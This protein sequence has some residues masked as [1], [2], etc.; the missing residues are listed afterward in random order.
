MND[1]PHEDH[2]FDFL[3]D[4]D[5]QGRP[6]GAVP[7]APPL[8]PRAD[9]GVDLDSD[10]EAFDPPEDMQA[11][12][13]RVLAARNPLQEAAQPLL[14]MLAEM[15]AS[16]ES[17]AAVERLRALLVRELIAFQK[18]CDKANLPWKH[19]AAV[20]Y[21][22][23][24]AL[25]EAANRTRWGGGGAWAAR[26]LLI[27]FER[28][29]EGG[30]KFFLLIGRMATDPQA[31]VDVL[32]VLYRILGLGFEGRYSVIVDGRRHLEQ[33]RQRLMTLISGAR[34]PLA[35]ELSP[36]W[37]GEAPGTMHLLRGVPAWASATLAALIVL[38]L[39]GWFK[40]H[41]LWSGNALEA[42]IL[43]IGNAPPVPPAPAPAPKPL[44]LSVLLKDEIARGLVSVD[45]D[46]THSKVI[47][48]GDYMFMS[49]QSAVR[50]EVD[51]V[52]ARVAKEV[53]RVGGN[54]TVTGH[55]DG[56][57]IRGAG[58]ASNQA[59]SEAR[60]ALVAKVLESYGTPGSRIRALGVGDTQPVA[61]DATAAGRARNRR[62]EILVTG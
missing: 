58:F 52:L 53:A 8:R 42:K 59:L 57:R 12:L 1:H 7:T 35:L 21:C 22:L 37:R 62:V 38:A 47:F 45:E 26:S 43:D 32:E 50:P 41:L 17:H 27:T 40:Y 51:P 49:G 44:R 5:G 46:A 18:L 4:A 30:E 48:S 9:I 13:A 54:V 33:I 14:R 61:D 24:T 25:D 16:L 29:V 15:P 3:S 36:H 23:C 55:S 20:R 34:D 28:E 60:A 10:A 19:M 31:Y 6:S 2:A 11:R 39:F 56:Q